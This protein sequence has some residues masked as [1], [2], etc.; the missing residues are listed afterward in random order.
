[1]CID[2]PA[3]VSAHIFHLFTTKMSHLKHGRG[4][5]VMVIL[6]TYLPPEDSRKASVESAAKVTFTSGI[7]A[8]KHYFKEKLLEKS[9]P[10]FSAMTTFN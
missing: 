7:Y 9:S 1:M 10:K 6:I 8:L 4:E 2:C 5:G 3:S